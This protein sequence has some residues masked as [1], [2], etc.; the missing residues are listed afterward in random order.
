[1][2]SCGERVF[3]T[4]FRASPDAW[5]RFGVAGAKGSSAGWP[6]D[7]RG[8]AEGAVFYAIR[9]ILSAERV[10]IE[11]CSCSYLWRTDRVLSG[12]RPAVDEADAL[13]MTEIVPLV[14]PVMLSIAAVVSGKAMAVPRRTIHVVVGAVMAGV[15]A[16]VGG[17]VCISLGSVRVEML[18]PRDAR[19]KRDR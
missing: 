2:R 9:G 17:E 19:L 12:R 8:P 6:Y 15:V 10:L 3:V 1:M 7:D 16:E 11:G 5:L 14:L 18:E 13:P 4:L